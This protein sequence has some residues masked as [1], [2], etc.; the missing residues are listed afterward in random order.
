M[1]PQKLSHEL[2]G[3]VAFTLSRRQSLD[4]TTISLSACALSSGAV[5]VFAS[6]AFAGSSDHVFRDAVPKRGLRREP[7]QSHGERILG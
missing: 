3:V 7:V 2:A 1:S 4:V 5:V 6:M